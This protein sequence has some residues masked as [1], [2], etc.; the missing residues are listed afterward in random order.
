M[1]IYELNK[2]QQKA[3]NKLKKAADECNKLKIGFI[4]KNGSI[5]ADF[6]VDANYEIECITYGYPYNNINNLG[7]SSYADDQNLHSFKLTTKGRKV[8]EAE[9][10]IEK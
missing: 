2:E 9:F 7:G 10:G 1:E 4:N 3:F 6:D 5:I 8:F